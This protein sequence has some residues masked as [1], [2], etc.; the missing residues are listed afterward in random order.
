MPET[1]RRRGC[2]QPVTHWALGLCSLHYGQWLTQ[3]DKDIMP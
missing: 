3:E 1:C 2:H